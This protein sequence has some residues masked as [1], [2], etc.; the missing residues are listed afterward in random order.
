MARQLDEIN[1]SGE[2]KQIKLGV[3]TP[4]PVHTEGQVFYDPVSRALSVHSD[5]PDTVLNVGQE[6]YIRVINKSGATILN[7]M[8]CRHN[9]VD[10]TTNK[11][12]IELAKAESFMHARVL[13]VATHDIAHDTE[14]FLTTHGR[15][16]GVNMGAHPAGQP[17]YLSPHIAGGYSI[18]PPDIASQVGG[19]LTTGANGAMQ[20]SIQ[21]I[22]S[23]PTFIGVLTNVATTY[24]L[25]STPQTI[26]NYEGHEAIGL[27][28]SP[29]TGII[30]IADTGMHR[31]SCTF[32]LTVTSTA[33]NRG[34][35][36]TAYSSPIE[37]FDYFVP[38]PKDT[39]NASGSFGIPVVL[40]A[41]D[42]VKLEIKSSDNIQDVAFISL[43]F[44]IESLHVFK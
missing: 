11:P 41:G 15:V 42:T 38:V 1:N 31:V 32:S 43:A 27:T 4:E 34:L 12:K 35:T 21:N 26:L 28:V 7:G 24:D 14:G 37:Q 30:L 10:T 13:G 3:S 39:V 9:G 18:T 5:I 36:L 33:Q 40:S 6:S 44:D 17:L 2:L 8:A 19:V 23:L 20:I 25:T 16:G 29:V 22:I